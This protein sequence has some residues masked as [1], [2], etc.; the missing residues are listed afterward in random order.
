[1][2]LDSKRATDRQTDRERE[3]E[4]KGREATEKV[5]TYKT[6]CNRLTMANASKNKRI[7]TGIEEFTATPQGFAPLEEINYRSN[8]Y[9]HRNSNEV[10]G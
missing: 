5:H 9:N 10:P 3:S 1:M 2:T 8:D 4:R 6:I 7:V